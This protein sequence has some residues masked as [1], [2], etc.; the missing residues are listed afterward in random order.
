MQD[1]KEPRGITR[2]LP[3]ANSN[4]P[5]T[6]KERNLI[7]KKAARAYEKYLDALR[8]DWRNDPNSAN[9]PLRVAKA[10]VNDIGKGC[11]E[12]PPEITA[13]PADG[14]NGMVFE[15]NIPLRSLCSHHHAPFMG[16]AYVA[17][18][19]RD[20]N[21]TV[22]G[23]SKLNRIVDFYCRRPQIQEALTKQI[24]DA[25]AEVCVNNR[26]VAVVLEATHTCVC[27]RGVKHDGTVMKT[28]VLSGA[29]FDDP[30]TREEFYFFVNQK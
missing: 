3:T 16:K 27:N 8:I 11:Y 1:I 12:N 22:I 14:Y 10:F 6:E 30:K 5:R 9:T 26:G 18:I 28:S 17:Y 15:G 25:I 2:L 24:H 29:F 19:P 4:I 23:L 20:E 7:I 21:G 13:F